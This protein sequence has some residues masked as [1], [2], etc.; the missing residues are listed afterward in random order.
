[1]MFGMDVKMA[2]QIEDAAA[3]SGH[4]QLISVNV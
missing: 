1:M 4:Y 2:L 3:T